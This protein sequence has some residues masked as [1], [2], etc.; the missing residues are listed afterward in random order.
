MPAV[1]FIHDR[2]SSLNVDTLLALI[3]NVPQVHGV[4]LVV[5][6]GLLEGRR[7]WRPLH[8]RIK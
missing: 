3:N 1:P 4:A 8:C 2:F 7:A 6:R 5:L